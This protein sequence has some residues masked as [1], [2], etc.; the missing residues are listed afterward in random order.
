M[1]KLRENIDA[2]ST[3]VILITLALFIAALFTEGFTHD[4][5]LEAGVFIVSVKIIML[6]YQ[7]AE[8]ARSVDEKL[9]RI[10]SELLHAETLL[11]D[12]EGALTRDMLRAATTQRGDN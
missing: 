11:Q 3:I 4:L 12:G 5:L 10:Y 1:L 6:S 7:S 2:P 8:R 9:E